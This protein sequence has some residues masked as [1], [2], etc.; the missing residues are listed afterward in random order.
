MP[1]SST[2]HSLTLHS[3]T[4]RSLLPRD[5]A[6]TA[7]LQASAEH[8]LA[9]VVLLP[10]ALGAGGEGAV[11]ATAALRELERT[12]AGTTSET[13]RRINAS[14][15]LPWGRG[16][17]Y[18]LA[19]ALHGCLDHVVAAADLAERCGAR[20]PVAAVD[21]VAVLHRQAELT[22]AAMPRL[23]GARDLA[24]YWVEVDRLR[25]HAGALHRGALA[26]LLVPAAPD[27]AVGDAV[28]ELR[29]ALAVREVLLEL[30][31]AARAFAAIAHRVERLALEST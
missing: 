31:A 11:A 23:A 3:L 19:R 5:P 24:D 30:D 18:D 14:L 25:R 22:V 10:Q 7:L 2:R 29:A 17:T 15:V 20:L 16:D 26:A 12:C 4:L 6:L 13:A 27:A 28:E 21:L 1:R 9:G 8:L